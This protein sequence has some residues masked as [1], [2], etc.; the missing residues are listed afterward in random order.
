MPWRPE[1]SAWH[2]CPVIR[3]RNTSRST[4]SL[5][6]RGWYGRQ[7]CQPIR[8]CAPRLPGFRWR[9][10]CCLDATCKFPF[11]AYRTGGLCCGLLHGCKIAVRQFKAGME[12]RGETPL[13]KRRSGSTHKVQKGKGGEIVQPMNGPM[14]LWHFRQWQQPATK[15]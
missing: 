10:Q 8:R 13:R 14:L 9:A 15:C 6:R 11:S 2:Y 5:D 1:P 3:R 12:H 4:D 7:A